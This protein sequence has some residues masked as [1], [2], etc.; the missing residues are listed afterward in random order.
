M[1][2]FRGFRHPQKFFNDENILDYGRS[3]RKLLIPRSKQVLGN[4]YSC[5]AGQLINAGLCDDGKISIL[6]LHFKIS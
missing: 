6:I 5:S 3:A 2:N 4:C 1:I